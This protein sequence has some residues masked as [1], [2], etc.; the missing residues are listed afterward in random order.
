M[1]K[2]LILFVCLFT[3]WG[4]FK[5]YY[6]SLF[7]AYI[8]Y[9]YN[10]DTFNVPIDLIKAAPNVIPNV[11][12]TTIPIKFLQA[13]YYEELDSIEVAKKMYFESINI[14]PYLRAIEAELSGLYFDQEQYDSAYYYSKIAFNAIPNSN[15][16]RHAYFQVLKEKKDTTA[17]LEA[18]NILKKYDNDNHWKEY[19]LNRYQIVGSGDNQVIELLKEYKNRFG[20]EDD[21][22]TKVLESI[23]VSGSKNVVLSVSFSEK[24]D[25]LFREKDYENAARLFELAIEYDNSDYI[26]YENAAIS[27]YLAG[28]YENAEIYFDRVINQFKPRNGKS[29]FYKGIMLVELD[30]NEEACVLLK[31]AVELKFS[32]D[33]SIQVY[34]NYCN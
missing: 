33:G 12:L 23:L 17:L 4:N 20:Y 27:Y 19:L 6:S 18:F 24:A 21:K 32:N 10:H 5:V 2:S 16:H 8:M 25:T 15:V 28:N 14:N 3:I 29:E 30:R 9:D 13:R 22:P 7:Q 26:F 11:T 31:R 1:K 34:N